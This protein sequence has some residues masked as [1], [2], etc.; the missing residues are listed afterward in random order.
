MGSVC[1]GIL[2][3]M[4]AGVP[5]KSP[6]AGI[7]MGLVT[8]KNDEYAVLTDIQGIEDFLGDMDFKVAGTAEGVTALQMDIKLTGVTDEILEQALDQARDARLFILEKM[9]ETI[10]E[11]RPDLSDYA[12][13]MIRL[14]INPERIGALIGPGGKTIRGIVEETKATVDVENDGTVYIGS[15]DGEAA[16][17]AIAMVEGLTKEIEVGEK[18]TGKVVRITDFGAFIELIPG[19]DGMVHISELAN[20]RVPSVEDVLSLGDEVEVLVTDIDQTG[21]VR[22]SR[23]A[24]LADDDNEGPRGES[25]GPGSQ[26]GDDRGNG[27]PPRRDDR[28]GPPRRGGPPNRPR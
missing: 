7:A 1:S 5:I 23:R 10:A 18:Y 13:R 15:S 8:G 17:K 9:R 4:D 2:S 26:G 27:R 28:G 11:S 14:Q 21:R 22:L 12:P 24:L 16:R 25:N 20:Y 19:R 3:L 6:V